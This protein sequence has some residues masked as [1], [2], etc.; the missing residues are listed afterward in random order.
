MQHVQHGLQLSLIVEY[1]RAPVHDG[2]VQVG[3]SH[4]PTLPLY[5]S[6]GALTCEEGTE[7]AGQVQLPM[8]DLTRLVSC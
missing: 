8:P 3:T 7:L 6:I 1:L 2:C 4:K 5:D